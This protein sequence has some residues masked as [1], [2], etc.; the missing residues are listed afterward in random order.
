MLILE[1]ERSKRKMIKFYNNV[2]ASVYRCYDKYGSSPR[3]KAASFVF[4]SL[5][6]FFAML[7]GFVKKIF[8][9]DLTTI[10]NFPGYKITFVVIG[11]FL[12]G[13]LWK[14]YSKENVETI[15]EGFED[16]AIS[17]RKFWGFIAVT[18]FILPWVVFAFY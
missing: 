7:L 15:I 10:R 13:F 6:G 14:F 11:F 5:L 18:A 1:L 8:S 4:L 3:Y 9:L 17:E 2:Y 16:K 12:L